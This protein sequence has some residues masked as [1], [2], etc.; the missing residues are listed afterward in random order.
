MRATRTRARSLQM[1]VLVPPVVPAARHAMTDNNVSSKRT[2]VTTA[3]CRVRLVHSVQSK[4]SVVRLDAFAEGGGGSMALLYICQVT[5][6]E[7]VHGQMDCVK[8][9]GFIRAGDAAGV[10]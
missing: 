4:N 9:V 3:K 2:A 5:T 8:C 7:S 1:N 6:H 10:P